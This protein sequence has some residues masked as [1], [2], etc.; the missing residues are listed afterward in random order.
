MDAIDQVVVQNDPIPSA[1]YAPP[2]PLPI[3]HLGVKWVKD[4]SKWCC[5]VE[6]YAEK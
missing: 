6:D 4:N 3:V 2:P 5:K 1:N